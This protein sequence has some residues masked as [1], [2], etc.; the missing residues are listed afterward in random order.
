MEGRA[1]RVLGL[2]AAALAL[3]CAPMARAQC[4]DADDDGDGVSS[5]EGDVDDSNPFIY[6]GAEQFC[7]GINNDSE[8]PEWPAVPTDERDNDG[9]DYPRCASCE[10][11]ATTDAVIKAS[12]ARNGDSYDPSL[13]AT[14]DGFLMTS[15]FDRGFGKSYRG[16]RLDRW[17]RRLAFPTTLAVVESSSPTS[18]KLVRGAGRL[19]LA[20]LSRPNVL[21]QSFTE[22]FVPTSSP[23]VL[24]GGPDC[25]LAMSE[26]PSMTWTG[27]EFAVVWSQFCTPESHTGIYFTRVAANGLPAAPTMLLVSTEQFDA[28]VSAV[29]NESG[30]AVAWI[31]G[32]YTPTP[33]F[34]LYVQRFDFSGVALGSPAVIDEIDPAGQAGLTS[35]VA[36]ETGYVITW[37]RGDPFG[38]S[39]VYFR[40]L[41]LSGTPLSARVRIASASSRAT[42]PQL[43][44]TGTDLRLVW[45]D[46]RDGPYDVFLARI[47]PEGSVGPERRISLSPAET[48]APAAA[49]SGSE[50]L[51]AYDVLTSPSTPDNTSPI[52][53]FVARE[54]CF[55]CDDV[56][57]TIHPGASE[58]CDAIDEDCDGLVDEEL[59]RTLYQD[60]DGDGYGN[61]AVTQL[62]CGTPAGWVN[63]AGDC[64]DTR[65]TIYPGALERCNGVDD[66]CNLQIDED[67]AGLDSD[68]DGVRNACDNCRFASN[69]YQL[70]RDHDLVGNACDNCPLAANPSQLDTDSDQRGDVCDNCPLA[71]NPSQADFDLD[72]HGDACDNCVFD[73]NPTQ[74]DFDHEDEGD[75]CDLDDGL[76]YV[77]S[78]DKNYREWQNESG[79]GSWNSYR[80]SLA[81]L[82]STGRYTQAPGSNPLAKRDC[83]LTHPYVLDSTVPAG[84]A[85]FTLVTGVSSG[86][87]GSLGSN[88]AGA[89][90]PN[91]NPCP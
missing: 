15:T 19:G 74:S 71:S 37:T 73:W 21:F 11:R 61:P 66:N 87:E 12:V 89:T 86:G 85:A 39:E 77:Y 6:P 76:I 47:S 42:F 45:L 78:T 14:P 79:Y 72:Q 59:D 81:V 51:I 13:V 50:L 26:S 49:W 23:V 8:A 52:D 70:D 53:L 9:D 90:R 43:V 38:A 32:H 80:G 65:A 40:M 36:T 34:H 16:M 64:N 48:F 67:A 3:T 60:L 58:T 84:S 54:S 33:D 20:W 10:I 62:A 27:S 7:D 5:C 24:S 88:S 63:Q 17:G 1:R 69:P 41:D 44:G 4:T 82:R 56:D 35:L 68:G 57:G 91:A 29:S 28:S 55:D 31:D 2:W 75:R 83:R 25:E 18:S 30:I 22:E 46:G